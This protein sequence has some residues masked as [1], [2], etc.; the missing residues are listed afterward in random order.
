MG[1]IMMISITSTNGASTR[2]GF[3][4][5][6][7]TAILDISGINR[8]LSR[9]REI[10]ASHS[11][12]EGFSSDSTSSASSWRARS[13][14]A[15]MS[16]VALGTIGYVRIGEC[17]LFG[18]ECSAESLWFL[19]TRHLSSSTLR[20]GHFKG[21]GQLVGEAAHRDDALDSSLRRNDFG[22]IGCEW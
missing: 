1:H 6:N 15:G 19:P 17:L 18:G 12:C 14:S 10:S 20:A 21:A 9:S 3:S 11:F 5:S 4:S 22:I 8:W 7:D 2:G 13:G 16:S